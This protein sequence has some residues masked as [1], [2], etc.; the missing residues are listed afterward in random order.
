MVGM[1]T[2]TDVDNLFAGVLEAIERVIKTM[3]AILLNHYARLLVV[4]S[5]TRDVKPS[6]DDGTN[7]EKGVIGE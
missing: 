3:A 7:L 2:I 5:S 6:C 1:P 4:W